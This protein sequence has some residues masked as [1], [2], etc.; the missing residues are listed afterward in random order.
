MRRIASFLFM[1]SVCTS[2]VVH[3]VLS[4]E[5]LQLLLNVLLQCTII[6]YLCIGRSKSKSKS[7]KG[8]GTKSETTQKPSTVQ[9]SSSSGTTGPPEKGDTS[10]SLENINV[11]IKQHAY[12]FEV[13]H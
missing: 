12:D 6:S 8:K 4:R 9:V 5:S 1:K 11:V 2:S 13:P 10:Y 7:G 3:V